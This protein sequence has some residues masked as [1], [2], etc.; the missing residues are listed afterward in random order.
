[1]QILNPATEELIREITEDSRDT[2]SKKFQ[3]LRNAQPGWSAL[4]IKQRVKV[5]SYFSIKIIP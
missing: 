5:F 4:G 2:L 3:L 1:M